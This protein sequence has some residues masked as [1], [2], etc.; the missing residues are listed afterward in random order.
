MTS[1]TDSKATDQYLSLCIVSFHTHTTEGTSRV[2][3]PEPSQNS[4]WCKGSQENLKG[5][6]G[7]LQ[8]VK[9]FIGRGFREETAG[10]WDTG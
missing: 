10:F 2:C 4:A 7:C 6:K 8:G 5:Y 3:A 1:P 9:V